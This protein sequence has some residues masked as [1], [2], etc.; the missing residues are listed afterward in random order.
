MYRMH[1]VPKKVREG[2]QI[3]LDRGYGW[4]RVIMCVLEIK[5]RCL[6][7]PRVCDYFLHV[8]THRWLGAGLRDI[9]E[10]TLP[11]MMAI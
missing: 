1:E 9:K 7:I 3:P 5:P 6:R 10:P 2:H 11:L 4:L 8:H